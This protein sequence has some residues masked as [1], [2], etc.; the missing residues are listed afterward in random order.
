MRRT[1]SL[2]AGDLKRISRDPILAVFIAVPVLLSTLL[3]FG[4]AP[5]RDFLLRATGFDLAPHYTFSAAIL[6]QMLPLVLGMFTGFIILDD[7]DENVLQYMA[8][9][10]LSRGGYL[11]YRLALPVM[12]GLIITLPMLALSDLLA[13]P[14]AALAPIT[15]LA[16]MQA[17]VVALFMA[18]FASNKVEGL[19][20]GKLCGPLVVGPLIGYLLAPPLKFLGALFPPFWITESFMAASA[21]DTPSYLAYLGGGLLFHLLLLMLLYRR[22]NRKLER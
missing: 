1:F 17:P 21:G 6:L 13:A 4:L 2:L 11:V 19:A 12:A 15:L 20:I 18:A 8:V 9:T 7:R 16:A 22:F 3:A 5:A 14:I 10:P